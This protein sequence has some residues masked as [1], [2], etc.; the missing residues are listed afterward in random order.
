L[1]LGLLAALLL[2]ACGA[3]GATSPGDVA[4]STEGQAA[5]ALV[6]TDTTFTGALDAS[7]TAWVSHPFPVSV[8]GTLTATL[9]WDNRAA[10]LNLFLNDASGGRAA[11]AVNSAT[12]APE[13]FQAE[14]S[15]TGVYQLGIKAKAGSAHYTLRVHF[16]PASQVFTFTG[17]TSASGTSWI[18]Q[19]FQA[20]QGQRIEA[21][22]DWADAKADLDLYLRDP[23]VTGVAHANGTGKPAQVAI[24]AGATGAWSAG[25]K[26][27]TGSTAYTLTVRVGQVPG[28]FA[29]AYPGQ[30]APGTLYWGATS[31]NNDIETRHE[32]PSGHVLALRRSYYQWSQRTTGMVNVARTDL[33]AGRLPWISVKTPT[34]SEMAAGA[35]DAE[36]DQM[37]NALGALPGPVWLT[38]FH[39][40]ENDPDV[41]TP[42][43][44]VAMNRRVR[45]RM[46]ALGIHN[47][48]LGPCLMS[49][50]FKKGS[51]RNP[52]DWWADG[53]YDFFGVD[54]YSR[55]EQTTLTDDAWTDIR[56]F[57]AERGVNVAVGEWGQ[58]GTDAAAGQ[59]V[60]DWFEAGIASGTDGQGARVVGL[61]AFDSGLNSPDGS[62]ELE[63]AQLTAFHEVMADP[64]VAHLPPAP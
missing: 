3:P 43:Q 47:V 26:C 32:G 33:A 46:T 19:G 22:L 10:D 34:W 5:Q 13:S 14:L 52:A 41:G 18:V 49:F 9:D 56:R 15:T 57:A 24:T 27:K 62:W 4:N 39:E 28:G 6:P 25:I 11:H 37:L 23:S 38:V 1:L 48:A 55:S 20:A 63:G 12:A 31:P 45:D 7:G 58:R 54:H 60:H 2:A 40:P 35:H 16:E 42:A 30:P 61:S 21:S 51:G 29:P 44:H 64:R 8:P 53:I 17:T 59:K 50:T 36:I